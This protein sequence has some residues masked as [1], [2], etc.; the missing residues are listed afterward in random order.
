MALT[1]FFSF[2][3]A[4]IIALVVLASVCVAMQAVVVSGFSRHKMSPAD[5]FE[6]LTELCVLIHILILAFMISH[7]RTD[8][9][10]SL[11]LSSGY[12]TTRY[13]LFCIITA[14]TLTAGILRRRPAA[15][16]I[17]PII[18]ST[19]PLTE[20]ALGHTFPPIYT[21]ALI[22]W[23]GRALSICVKR[24]NARRRE[25]S[26][27][28]IKEA[29][30]A[31][32]SG[33]LYY[34]DNGEIHLIN[35]RMQELALA[36]TGR[37]WRNGLELRDAL[38]SGSAR[39]KPEPSSLDG[40]K[41]YRLEDGTAWLFRE[42]EMIIKGKKHLQLSAVDVT[43]RWEL[44][45]ELRTQEAEL[46][47]RGDELSATLETLDE[48][49]RGEE[50]LRLKSKVHDLMAQRL[51]VLTRIFRAE[52]SMEEA[53]LIRFADDMLTRAQEEIE[54]ETD[55]IETLCRVYGDV[56]V[57]ITIEGQAP[58][59]AVHA[60]FYAQFVREGVNNA[61]RHGLATQIT[62]TCTTLENGLNLSIMN[63]GT[64]SAVNI[65]EGSGITELRRRLALLHG[66]LEIET[67]PRFSLK[68]YIPDFVDRRAHDR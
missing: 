15:L 52:M 11:I 54:N 24:W 36:L 57:T 32:H 26:A 27:F 28:S 16:M 53:D 29:M 8:M 17:I 43:R 14:L 21:A 45:D 64:P 4:Q 35:H 48:L 55:D 41:V 50:L 46:R 66:R 67:R 51:T 9:R 42:H 49:R 68:V 37:A 25:V 12:I 2:G 6:N 38:L 44:T 47:L 13:A 31:L 60:S 1:A 22:F 65:V 30:D 23:L 34:K 58:Q 3:H 19:L 61:V 39:I 7:V 33:L 5:W 40:E 62:V 56:G 59:N 10:E 18:I 20:R 63:N